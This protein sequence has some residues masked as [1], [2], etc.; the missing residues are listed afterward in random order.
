[1]SQVRL[2]IITACRNAQIFLPSCVEN[3][4]Q[5]ITPEI[6]HIFVDGASTDSTA[7]QIE[8]FAAEYPHIRWIS[9]P[10][11]GQSQAM[12]KGIAMAKGSVIGFLNVDDV[13]NPGVLQRALDIFSGIESPA[14]VAANCN[15]VVR[16]GRVA[17]HSRPAGLS[18]E[19]LLSGETLPPLNPTSYFYHKVLHDAGMCGPYDEDEHN[20]MDIRM[21]PK[22]IHRAH[23]HYFDEPWGIFR[24]HPMCK[25]NQ[26]WLKGNILEKIDEILRDYLKTLPESEKH[27][28][29]ERRRRAGNS[30]KGLEPLELAA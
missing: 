13:Y 6:E 16:S 1:M 5:Q 12:N 4:A 3:V 14:F 29:I 26:N 10:D 28:I 24:V 9:E 23:V 30:M 7:K 22:L 11:T 21:L 2:S 25:T 8:R 15:L 27:P 20:Y 17:R 18:I 19:T